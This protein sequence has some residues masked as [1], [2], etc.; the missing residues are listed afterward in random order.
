MHVT[1]VHVKVKREHV[2]DFVEATREN[3]VGSVQEAGNMRFDV[4]QLA[5]DPTQFVLYEAYGTAEDAVAH[6]QAAHYLKWREKVEPW[7]AEPRQGVS[8]NGVFPQA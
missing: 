7:M 2:D 1:I 8:Y 4:L 3:H 5:S 6:K